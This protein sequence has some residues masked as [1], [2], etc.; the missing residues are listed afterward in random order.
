M[1]LC[2]CFFFLLFL[3]SS[4][5]LSASLRSPHVSDVSWF[6]LLL[7]IKYFV[8]AAF[9]SVPVITLAMAAEGLT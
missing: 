9:L 5:S 6:R 1:F 4:L 7:V 8:L 2:C 3:F